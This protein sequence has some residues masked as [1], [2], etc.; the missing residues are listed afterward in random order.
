MLPDPKLNLAQTSKLIE[1]WG[2]QPRVSEIIIGQ[3][4]L[5][6]R[7][8]NTDAKRFAD[9]KAAIESSEVRAIW[10]IRG[11][12]GAMRLL[13]YLQTELS[14]PAE[15]KLFI[16][17][18]DLTLLHG[19]FNQQW[20]W[21]TIH[22]PSALQVAENRVALED[23]Q[24][25]KK[26]IFAEI[27]KVC[28]FDLQPLNEAASTQGKITD[29]TVIGGNLTLVCRVLATPFAFAAR[30][31]ILLLE[32][33]NESFRAVDGMLHQ[34]EYSGVFAEADRS[35]ADKPRA[36]ILG[37]VQA[38]EPG[39][40]P[41]IERAIHF[42][43]SKLDKLAIPVLRCRNIGHGKGNHPIPMGPK[44]SLTLGKNPCLEIDVGW[45]RP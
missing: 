25:L 15:V 12:Y 4:P 10:G 43:A 34:L 30:D 21:N 41:D 37:D 7:L 40:Q 13:S 1:S 18:S 26:M 17:F 27:A 6:P 2:L 36:V 19:Y 22:G 38:N 5:F 20:G 28:Y 42:F 33:L 45:Q 16:G 8:A 9:L 31:K 32:D 11:G 23:A 29:T 39:Q 44:A 3:D 35:R 24:I 14:V